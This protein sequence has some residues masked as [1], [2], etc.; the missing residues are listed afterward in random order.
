[1]SRRLMLRNESGGELPSEYQQVEWIQ[2]AN[3]V[4]SY[5]NTGIIPTNT[6]G[7]KYDVAFNSYYQDESAMGVRD[8]T[9]IRYN[10]GQYPNGIFVGWYDVFTPYVFNPSQFQRVSI[11]LNLYNSRI[12][13][14]NDS[15]VMSDLRNKPANL[16]PCFIFA[17]NLRGSPYF[18]NN[19]VRVYGV[20]YTENNELTHNFIPCY[21]KSDGEIGM[22][23]TVLQTF[24]TNSGDGAFTKGADV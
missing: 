22:Y 2:R 16:Y 23:D 13:K 18:S 15:I 21:R 14:C 11:E 4:K 7:V 9:G 1:M 17:M 19:S 24:H 10:I 3:R 12:A 5:I 20:Y 8:D 6:S